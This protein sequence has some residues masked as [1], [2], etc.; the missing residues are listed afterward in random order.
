M[1]FHQIT[2]IAVYWMGFWTIVN[3]LMPPRETFRNSS[4]KT[5]ARYNTIL[6]LIAY[7]G[8]LNV[9]QLTVK[10]YDSVNQG[11]PSIPPHQ[12]DNALLDAAASSQQTGE[13]IGHAQASVP[14][15]EHGPAPRHPNTDS[16]GSPDQPTPAK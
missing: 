5:Q 1:T 6:M 11:A 4:A 13:A 16:T 15:S 14:N 12:L 2:D 10:M 8:A 7:Y 3:A 9:R